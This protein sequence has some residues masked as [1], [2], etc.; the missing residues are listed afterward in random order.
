MCKTI[1]N[2]DT[3][4][5]LYN[6]RL[7]CKSTDTGLTAGEHSGGGGIRPKLSIGHPPRAS[8]MWT[9]RG[10]GQAEGTPLPKCTNLVHWT[11]R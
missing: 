8:R 4:I 10:I 3:K 2:N 1:K 5:I 6:T 11:F 9:A 7:K